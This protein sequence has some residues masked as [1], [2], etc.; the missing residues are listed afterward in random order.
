M[1]STRSP[2]T[3]T[4]TAPKRT[5][6]PSK[7]KIGQRRQTYYSGFIARSKT[8]APEKAPPPPIGR[9]RWPPARDGDRVKSIWGRR[10][11]RRRRRSGENK[12]CRLGREMSILPFDF[13]GKGRRV[14][15]EWGISKPT[16]ITRRP[17]SSLHSTYRIYNRV[18]SCI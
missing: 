15:V 13:Q 10:R 16:R 8:T 6:K 18:H 7:C 9:R 17:R 2:H 1:P 4:V 3:H 14:G 11:R 5:K 12:R